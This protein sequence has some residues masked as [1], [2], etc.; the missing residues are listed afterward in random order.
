MAAKTYKAVVVDDEPLCIANLRTSLNNY[1]EITLAG[2]ALTAKD[3]IKLILSEKPDLLFLDVELPG[4]S[5]IELLKELQHRINWWMQVIFY[6][7]HQKYWLDA[8]RQSAFD[9]LLKPYTPEEFSTIMKR[10]FEFAER[11]AV[12]WTIEKALSNLLPSNQSFLVPDITG[13]Q[14]MRV[15]E[16]GC[17]I[18]SKPKRQWNALL[19]DG[20]QIALGRNIKSEHVLSFS[21]YFVQINR[22]QIVN[23]NYLCSIKGKTCCLIPPFDAVR[24]LNI[25]RNFHSQVQERLGLI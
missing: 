18:Y 11:G 6:T 25:S 9:Y 19:A 8:L 14:M 13:Y 22:H 24:D 21:S 10:F 20:K 4:M 17:F 7:S 15:N 2:E 16:V 1:P 5:G 3:G 12:T 23:I